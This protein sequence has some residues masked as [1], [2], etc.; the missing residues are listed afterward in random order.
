MRSILIHL[1]HPI[2]TVLSTLNLN[3]NSSNSVGVLNSG[4]TSH[5]TCSTKNFTPSH[6]LHHSY[7]T[8]PNSQRVMVES[9]STITYTKYLTLYNVCSSHFIISH[10]STF[11]SWIFI[12]V[13]IL[14]CCVDNNSFFIQDQSNLREIGRADLVGWLNVFKSDNN[15]PIQDVLSPPVPAHVQNYFTCFMFLETCIIRYCYCSFY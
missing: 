8:L 2:G 4:A 12:K 10:K 14:F 11:S 15:S 6:T 13:F 1:P 7:F 9:I 3:L 5:I